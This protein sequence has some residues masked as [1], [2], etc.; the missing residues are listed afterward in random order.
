MTKSIKNVRSSDMVYSEHESPVFVLKVIDEQGWEHEIAVGS[1]ISQG[2]AACH[3]LAEAMGTRFMRA[4][5]D[6][7]YNIVGH[8]IGSIAYYDFEH[9]AATCGMNE[10]EVQGAVYRAENPELPQEWDVGDRTVRLEKT[11]EPLGKCSES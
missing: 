6:L 10:L 8:L 1:G 2:D 4:S 7:M 9:I 5:P 3:L 11:Y